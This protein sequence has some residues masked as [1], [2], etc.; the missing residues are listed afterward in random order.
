MDEPE[1]LLQIQVFTSTW[2][3]T[4]LISDHNL[5]LSGNN[6]S[7][8]NDNLG[9]NFMAGATSRNRKFDRIGIN[10]YGQQVFDFFNHEGFTDYGYIEYH[11][12]EKYCRSLWTVI[13]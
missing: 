7:F 5:V 1:I 10:S 3:N 2:N 6:Y 11:R 13:F 12:R 8:L 9:F 4:N